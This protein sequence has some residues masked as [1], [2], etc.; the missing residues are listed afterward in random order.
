MLL[1]EHPDHAGALEARALFEAWAGRYEESLSS[2]DQLLAIAPDNGAAR[3]QQAQVLSW[4]SRFDAS[5]AVYDSILTRNP[6]DVESR[7][8]LATALAFSDD[9]DESIAEYDKIL[10]RS[11]DHIGALQG[12]GRVLGWANRL[13]EAEG[14]LRH[15]LSL[16]ERNTGTLVGLAQVLRWQD[17]N[18]AALEMLQRAEEI[19]PTNSDVRE[20]LRGV[21]LALDP[22]ANPSFVAEHDSDGNTML[23]T[24]L[25]TAF[26]P[27]PR[28]EVRADGYWRDLQQSAFGRSAMGGTLTASYQIEPGWIVSAGGGGSHTDGGGGASTAAYRFGLRSLDARA[29]LAR[30]R[31]CGTDAILGH[32]GQR[33]HQRVLLRLESARTGVHGGRQRTL[34]LVPA[35]PHRGLFRSRLLWDCRAH[36]PLA[37]EGW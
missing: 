31:G 32:T 19:A 10:A 33:P 36:G 28:L 8:G 7:L 27:S 13:V 14:V 22:T 17:R 25:A 11:P 5:R 12:K 16:D 21:H 26:H 4:A 2:Y 9:L 24:S 30:R 15:A 29:R 37:R 20:Q 3:R 1:A 6:D 35:G 23:T 18:A 34:L